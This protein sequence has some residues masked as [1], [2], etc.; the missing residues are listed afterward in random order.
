MSS[1]EGPAAFDTITRTIFPQE[2]ESSLTGLEPW[3]LA[4]FLYPDYLRN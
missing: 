1:A 3:G 2:Q 4:S